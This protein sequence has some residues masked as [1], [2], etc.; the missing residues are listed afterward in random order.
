MHYLYITCVISYSTSVPD[1]IEDVLT[2]QLI[3]WDV[4][5][6]FKFQEG[7]LQVFPTRG[8]GASRPAQRCRRST[9]NREDNN[10]YVRYICVTVVYEM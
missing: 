3:S 7:T 10:I 4:N 2:L 9:K 5:F 8:I 1:P 6:N